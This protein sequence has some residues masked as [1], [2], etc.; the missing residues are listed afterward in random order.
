MDI[1]DC[2]VCLI[3]VQD[4]VELRQDLTSAQHMLRAD[5]ESRLDERATQL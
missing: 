2:N 4:V 3:I 5:Y 1:S